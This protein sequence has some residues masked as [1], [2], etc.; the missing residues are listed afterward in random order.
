M[1]KNNLIEK[2]LNREV[3]AVG[4]GSGELFSACR[5]LIHN[6]PIDFT[7][8]TNPQLTDSF[9]SGV[10]V[11]LPVALNDL[12]LSKTVL[13]IYSIEYRDQILEFCKSFPSLR[14]LDYNSKE[15]TINWSELYKNL[16]IVSKFN[17][18]KELHLD[19]YPKTQSPL[20]PNIPPFY[21]L[22][23][24][25]R[26]TYDFWLEF[27]RDI[28]KEF[29]RRIHFQYHTDMPGDIAEFGTAS[30][31]TASILASAI[32]QVSYLNGFT[33][34]RKLHLFDSFKG[35]PK[36]NNQL[37]KI[38][39]WK[40][41]MFKERTS[42]ELFQLIAKFLPQENI[43][44]YEGWYVDTLNNID[45][46]TKFGMI[47]VDCDTYESTY[48]VL[49]YLFKNEH[50]NNGCALYFDDW[51]CGRSSPFLG[52]QLAWREISSKYN[53]KFTDCGDYSALG[54]KIIIHDDSFKDLTAKNSLNN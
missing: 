42:D 50:I 9:K 19:F 37:D 36:I 46:S 16:N 34:F 7:I 33:P 22:E 13:I 21:G 8:N 29:T 2:I 3:I 52:E 35:L 12:D 43:E 51:H 10:R 39:G 25:F 26:S 54:R 24:E 20:K 38:G 4:W 47:N 11:K 18:I 5:S 27:R 41:G 32:A 44:I 1:N 28:Y 45:K 15:L 17:C 31:A 49:D 23:D 48:Q 40:E 30:G 6:F 14:V 53:L